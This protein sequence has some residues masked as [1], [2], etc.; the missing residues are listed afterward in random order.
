MLRLTAAFR[1]ELADQHTYEFVQG[2]E[3]WKLPPGM[4]D[5]LAGI[6]IRHTSSDTLC[7]SN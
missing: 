3:P 4:S 7:L 1:Y 2:V 5:D 6:S